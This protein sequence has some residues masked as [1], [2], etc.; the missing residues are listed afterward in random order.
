MARQEHNLAML[1]IAFGHRTAPRE[2]S[3]FD[4]QTD[5]LGVTHR[6]VVELPHLA[7]LRGNARVDR[8]VA[9]EDAQAL[10]EGSCNAFVPGLIPTMLGVAQ[11]F[12]TSAGASVIMLGV[13]ENLGPPAPPTGT[14]YPD[15]RREFHHLY[16]QVLQYATRDRAQIRLQTPLIGMSR[17]EII[18]VGLRLRAPFELTWSCLRDPESACGTCYGCA[19]RARGFLE[20]GAPDPLALL[21]HAAG[22]AEA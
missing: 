7:E 10:R 21:S 14:L 19:T 9:I 16:A 12:A 18:S 13:S 15:Y 6:F 4:E 1:H 8:S 17:Q 2:R 5:K 3:C 20:A 22:P 11:S